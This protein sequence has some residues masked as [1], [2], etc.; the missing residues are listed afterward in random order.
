M[1]A[2]MLQSPVMD[3]HN[4][5]LASLAR[6]PF[7]GQIHTPSAPDHARNEPATPAPPSPSLLTAIQRVSPPGSSYPIDPA[8][9]DNS[10]EN[11]DPSLVQNSGSPTF[12]AV[13]PPCA[14]CGAHSTPLWR[15]DGE[16]KA[17][18]NACGK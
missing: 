5:A 9:K 11:I 3:M 7:N 10:P 18:C 13:K 2:V 4:P 1:P 8:L 16:G 15:R 12:G 17:V 14:N 6:L